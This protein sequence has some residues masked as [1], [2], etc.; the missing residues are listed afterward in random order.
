[1]TGSVKKKLVTGFQAGPKSSPAITPTIRTRLNTARAHATKGP[2]L[3][4]IALPG[5]A[6]F[7]RYWTG[8]PLL[9]LEQKIF[10]FAVGWQIYELTDSA[11][12]LGLIGLVQFLPQF[13]LALPAGHVADNFDRRHV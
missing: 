3:M 10:L 1:M 8:K 7:T 5:N 4:R 2:P 6:P 13:V 9:S 11:L 12:S